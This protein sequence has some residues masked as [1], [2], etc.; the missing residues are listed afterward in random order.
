M[1]KKTKKEVRAMVVAELDRRG[2]SGKV[3]L[4]SQVDGYQVYVNNRFYMNYPV[5]DDM[6]WKS[7]KEKSRR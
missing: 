6:D 2:I 1:K 3:T 5:Y 4:K 7:T